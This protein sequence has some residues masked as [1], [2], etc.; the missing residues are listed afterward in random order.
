VQDGSV[1]EFAASPA[2]HT[3][4]VYLVRSQAARTSDGTLYVVD[5]NDPGNSRVLSDS[6]TDGFLGVFGESSF[7][8]TAP[9]FAGDGQK[10][11]YLADRDTTTPQ[12][13]SDAHLYVIDLSRPGSA[14]KLQQDPLPA[15]GVT[16]FVVGPRGEK[17]C[18]RTGSSAHDVP[19]DLFV[20]DVA[21]PGAAIRVNDPT[22]R[23]TIS[24]PRF[25]RDG[26]RLVY[27][28]ND[29]NSPSELFL[30]ELS[31]PGV[32]VKLNAAL[33]A[34]AFVAPNSLSFRTSPARDQDSEARD[35]AR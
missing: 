30:V 23:N 31:A 17:V 15:D 12:N 27:A 8:A 28:A 7:G 5:T 18:Y 14:T 2:D 6:S 24:L 34:G 3:T 11:V 35:D 19:M 9:R 29:E 33:P 4:V 25:T 10:V 21:A 1:R 20:V 22:R 32:A 13:R 16:D 26:A